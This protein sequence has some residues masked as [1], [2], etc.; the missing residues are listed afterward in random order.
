MNKNTL[1][2]KETNASLVHVS[3]QG[4]LAE[5]KTGLDTVLQAITRKVSLA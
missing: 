2:L 4:D 1:V 3:N 5:F